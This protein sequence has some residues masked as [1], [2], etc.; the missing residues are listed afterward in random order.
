MAYQYV[1]MEVNDADRTATLTIN[2][3]DACPT[4][5]ADAFAQGSDWWLLKAFR[6]LDDALL[7][8]RMN[9]RDVALVL[10]R[11]TGDAA[12]VRATDEP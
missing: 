5:S 11:A 3:P 12:T 10:L 9:L 2:A 4:T 8:L 7:H 1:T 6:E